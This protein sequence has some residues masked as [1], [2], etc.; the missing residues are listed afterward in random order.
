M[1]CAHP[2]AH[3]AE[4]APSPLIS[5]P[6]MSLLL[7]LLF[8]GVGLG[9]VYALVALG[10]VPLIRSANVINFAQGEFSMLGA[11]LMVVLLIS[12]GAPYLLA[13][14]DAV[15]L[16]AVFGVIFAGITFWP[17]R[18]GGKIPVI[19]SRIGASILLANLVLAS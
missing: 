16:M 14:V 13:M 18:N 4:W 11:Y 15:A 9:S 2:A 5:G 8:T 19:I 7:Q 10:F 12:F 1:A 17:L 3:A 6:T